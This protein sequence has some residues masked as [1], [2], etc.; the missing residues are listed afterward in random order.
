MSRGVKGVRYILEDLFDKLDICND[1][2]GEAKTH[3]LIIFPNFCHSLLEIWRK[4]GGSEVLA[5]ELV[6]YY[7]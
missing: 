6:L 1:R 2:K 7:L 3:F 5:Q 4:S